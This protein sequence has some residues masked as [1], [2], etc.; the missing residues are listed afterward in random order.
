MDPAQHVGADLRALHPGTGCGA[1]GD[2]A[3]DL[4]GV[5]RF[6]GGWSLGVP[7]QDAVA[8]PRG[9]AFHV[10]LDRC[11]PVGI[12][13]VGD[14]AQAPAVVLARREREQARSRTL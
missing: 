6:E 12:A 10:C 4:V 13:A 5:V 14:A 3:T 11:G 7:G 1:T 8:E 2:V 9:E